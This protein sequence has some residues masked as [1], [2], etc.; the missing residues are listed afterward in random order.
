M[1]DREKLAAIARLRGDLQHFGPE[2][3]TVRNKAGQFV[4]F[5]FN[6]SQVELH[7]RIEAQKERTGMVRA[8]V[9]KG[10]QQGISTYTQARYYHRAS[11]NRGVNVYILTHEGAAT[12]TLFGMVDRYHTH[13][14]IAPHVGTSNS[15]ELVFDRLDSS[16]SVATAGQ[17]AAGRS[18]ATT[19]FH[20]SEVAFWPNASDHFAASVQ[21][22]PMEAGTEVILE[23]TSNGP[24]GEFYER[25]QDAMNGTSNYELIFLPWWLQPEYY[26]DPPPGFSLSRE[27]EDGGVSEA[28]YM[29]MHG[30]SLGHMVWRRWKISELR[31]VQLF[32]RE[33]PA[34]IAEAWT[35]P[36]GMTTFIDPVHVI[37]ARKRQGIEPIGPLVLGVD[38]SS[39]GGDRFAVCAR[40]GPAVMWTRFRKRLT[41]EEGVQWIA[42]LIEELQPARVNI[43]GGNIGANIIS[44]LRNMGPKYLEIVRG[45]NF[46]DTS[47]FKMAKPKVP[48][49]VNRRAE[50]YARARDWLEDPAG[51]SLPDDDA[52]QSDICA[53]QLKPQLNNDYLLESKKD[54]KARGVRSPDLAD[55]FALTFAFTEFFRN[56]HEE[57][58]KMAYGD[59]APETNNM[60]EED[61]GEYGWMA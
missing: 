4:K 24:T 34:T 1:D 57:K 13:N 25:C 11:M 29:E 55:A 32:R 35:P 51:V 49:P 39:N 52:L 18:K 19:L 60:F 42:S 17:K 48:G 30:L 43:D 7:R 61:S 23:S 38:P 45:V 56:Y 58:P 8:L 26:M 41:H 22:V 12:D 27:P 6:P 3:L 46:G 59:L 36:P 21:G 14:P 53:P 40:R 15:K 16:Y 2:C 33:Y 31:S 50:M 37:R 5:S 20:G 47:Q 54:M 10:R 28:E 9:L 44:T